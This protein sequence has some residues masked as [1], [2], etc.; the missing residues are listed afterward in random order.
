MR[1]A[2]ISPTLEAIS[3]LRSAR[4]V[5]PPT[6][7][8]RRQNVEK[9]NRHDEEQQQQWRGARAQRAGGGEKQGEPPAKQLKQKKR[10]ACGKQAAF[11]R[12][13]FSRFACAVWRFQAQTVLRRLSIPCR[14]DTCLLKRA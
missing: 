10:I 4:R 7:S 5:C 1:V 8:E 6:A 13:E 12:S 9:Q 11:F 2:T 3:A 14:A